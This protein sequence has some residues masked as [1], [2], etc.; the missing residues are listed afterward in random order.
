M[1]HDLDFL[2]H[3]CYNVA[4]FLLVCIVLYQARQRR[5]DQQQVA[6]ERQMQRQTTSTKL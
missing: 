6:R 3:A 4:L 2:C 1:T 5:L